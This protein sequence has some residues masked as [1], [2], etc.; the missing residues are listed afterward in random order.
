[1]MRT[2]PPLPEIDGLLAAALAED[3][4]VAPARLIRA[5]GAGDAA[6]LDRDVTSAAVIPAGDAF[7]GAVVMRAGGV[8]CGLPVAARAWEL[9]ADACGM[10]D[11]IDVFPLVAEGTLVEPG[12]AVLEVEGDTRI[13]LAGERTALNVLMTLSGIA[14]EAR[15]WQDAAGA[16]LRV[17]DTRKTLPALRALSKYA[18]AVGGAYNHR[19]G[20]WDRVLIKDNHLARAGSVR[21]AVD[22]ARAAHPELRVEVEADALD[23]AVDA[24]RAGADIILLDNMDDAAVA[25]AVAAVRAACPDGHKCEI[26]VSGTVT[27]KRL[28]ALAA[29]GVDV[30]STSALTLAR[31]LDVGFDERSPVDSGG[32]R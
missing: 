31:P 15:L 11:A 28:P 19:V 26:E 23:Q 9:L 16:A 7:E 8:V 13:V 17:C 5:H 27:M 21:A 4:G 2:L 30:V 20:L 24:A 1:M 12:T 22:A 10:P 29:L 25:E 14:T 18:V 3:L 6:L 32:E